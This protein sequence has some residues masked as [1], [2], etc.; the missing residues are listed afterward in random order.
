[1]VLHLAWVWALVWKFTLAAYHEE[2]IANFID[3]W[4]QKIKEADIP[5]ARKA[6]WSD[7]L[8]WVKKSMPKKKLIT[9][10]LD[11]SKA[12]VNLFFENLQKTISEFVSETWKK[13]QK[14]WE[15]LV[16]DFTEL[17][18][19]KEK[20]DELTEWVKDWVKWLMG[21]KK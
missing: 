12:E 1:M 7:R 8:E 19:W 15:Q 20:L 11:Y 10:T 13:S 4:I 18:W 9:D 14:L 6:Y 5:D 2:R 21:E 17:L 3:T 16:T